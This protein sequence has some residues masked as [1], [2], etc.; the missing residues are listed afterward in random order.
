MNHAISQTP[1]CPLYVEPTLTEL[2]DNNMRIL[3][4]RINKTTIKEFFEM[5]NSKSR[6]EKYVKILRALVNCDGEAVISN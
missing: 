1:K 5:L 4:S 2:I 6:H 3:K